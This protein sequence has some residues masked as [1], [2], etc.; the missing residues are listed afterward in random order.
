MTPDA[1]TAPAPPPRG[2]RRR[3]S[4]GLAVAI[5]AL[6]L[7]G[8]QAVD[9]HQKLADTQQEVS[10][11]QAEADTASKELRDALHQAQGQIASLQTRLGASESQLADFRDQGE[12]LRTLRQDLARGREEAALLDIEQAITLAGQQLQLAGNVAAASLALQSADTRLARLDRPQ[13]LPLRQALAHDLAK[14]AAQPVADLA[15]FSLRL[16]QGLAA[17]DRLPLAGYGRPAAVTETAAPSVSGSW[18]QAAAGEMWREIKGL[19]RIQ[20][21]DHGEPALLAPDQEFFLR[22]NLKL[23]LLNARLALFSRDQATFRSE[24]KVAEDWLARYFAGEDKAV[25]AAQATLHQLAGSKLT[26]ELPT[27]DD[28]QAALRNLRNG[29]DKR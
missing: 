16:E 2:H 7:A 19:V 10:R 20:R 18:W 4:P 24:L 13:Y 27:L 17:I 15:G 23:R 29:K 1:T 21:F 12:A 3:F 14:L 28:S 26:L 11:R 5:A 22:E 25:Q 9:T 8:W 6:A